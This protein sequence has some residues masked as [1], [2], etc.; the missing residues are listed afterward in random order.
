MRN[1][2][3]TFG[4]AIAELQCLNPDRPASL[5]ELTALSAARDCIDELLS[6]CV[7]ELR[8]D[9]R[10]HHSWPEIAYALGA[11][12][13][14]AVKQKYSGHAVVVAT[15]AA[16]PVLAFW[17]AHA[18]RFAWDFLPVDFLHALYGQW[19]QAQDPG[20]E[21]LP[22]KAFT[23]RLRAAVAGSRRWTYTRSRPGALMHAAEP[24]CARIPLW[25]PPQGNGAVYGL[26]RA[27]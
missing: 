20:S 9:V 14:A 23:R 17:E 6:T 2:E 18:G 4:T 10:V 26:R 22:P 13:P 15:E 12:S 24:L 16:E 21:P 7:A 3:Q 25:S 11:T 5:D 27:V 8:A 19:A 1:T